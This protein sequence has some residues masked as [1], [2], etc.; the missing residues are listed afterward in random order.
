[1]R[2]PIYLNNIQYNI[3]Q[4]NHV[5]LT[6]GNDQLLWRLPEQELRCKEVPDLPF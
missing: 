2:T 4:D 6:K 1:M 5:L 3:I